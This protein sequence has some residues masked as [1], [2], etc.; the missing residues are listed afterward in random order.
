MKRLAL[1]ASVVVAVT[2]LGLLQ[3]A[4]QPTKSRAA[5]PAV[6]D[7]ATLE[8]QFAETMSGATLVGY[9]TTDGREKQGLSEEEYKLKSVKKLEKGDYWQFDYQYG[10]KGVV[11]PLPLEI[12]W[13]GDTPVITLTDAAIP[14][15]GTFSARVL[16]YRGE[17]AGTWSAKDH[18]GKLFGKV[19]KEEA[20]ETKKDSD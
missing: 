15:V 8:K 16:F 13:A 2:A 20:G 19:V 7:K 10:D 3:A 11:I 1:V 9:F 17:Y 12:K 18:G 6:P 4:D 5:A 14:G